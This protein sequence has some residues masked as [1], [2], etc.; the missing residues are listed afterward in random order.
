IPHG[1]Y[2]RRLVSKA[3]LRENRSRASCRRWHTCRPVEITLRCHHRRVRKIPAAGLHS[4]LSETSAARA[5]SAKIHRSPAAMKSTPPTSP[6]PPPP[7]PAPAA[8]PPTAPSAA[9][10]L[11]K[12]NVPAKSRQK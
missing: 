1:V 4:R 10:A 9:P 12:D 5:P 8:A 7:P 3:T 2:A 11:S 6:P